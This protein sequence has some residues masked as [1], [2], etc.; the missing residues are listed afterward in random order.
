MVNEV[1]AHTDL[2]LLD[3]IE[4]YNTTDAAI[5]IGGWYLSDSNANY[6]KYRIPDGTVLAAHEYRVFD[7]ND[8]GLFPAQRGNRRRRV[9]A[10]GRRRRQAHRRSSSTS[11]SAPSPTANRWAAGPTARAICIRMKNRTLGEP[12]DIA[13]NGP[14]IG[15]LLISEVMYRPSVAAG[16]NPDDYEYI[17]I[18]NPTDAA[19][20]LDNWRLSN[21][22]ITISPRARRSPRTSDAGGAPLQSG[23][24]A[25]RRETGEF[26]G[27]IRRRRRGATGGRIRRPFG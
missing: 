25:E 10:R 24:S 1:L 11:S 8:F 15:P 7:E 26:Q 6:Q 27:E 22:V 9:A 2:P 17:E 23:R 21:G 12:N 4:L 14:R 20:T 5:D 18:F 19:V 16:Q 13:G 3:S